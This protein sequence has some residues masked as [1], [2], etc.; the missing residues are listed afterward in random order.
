MGMQST[1]S[2]L[3]SRLSAWLDD[4]L[5]AEQRHEMEAWLREHPEDAA[6]VRLW[7]ADRDALLARLGPAVDEPVPTR[8]E[9]LVWNH[10][11]SI[12]PAGWQRLAA[13]IAAFVLGGAI[14][15]GI[16]WHW[17]VGGSAVVADAGWE[18]RVLNAH[19][20]YAP[21]LRHPVEVA[22]AG[23]TPEDSRA[24]EEQLSRWLTQRID[25]PVRLFDLR[26]LGFELLGGR[27]LADTEGPC[28]QLMYQRVGKAD[29]M[30]RVTV[31]MHKPDDVSSTLRYE[32][33]GE[34]GMF[35]WVDG[36]MGYA[37]VGALPREQLLA[38]AEA[39]HRQRRS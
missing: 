3:E 7:A 28:A 10:A 2:S 22:I 33:Q 35:Y 1:D 5:T 27:L 26:G 19:A 14:G 18:Q 25:R 21:D 8:L 34:L 38:L 32:R 15:A 24:Q 4:E 17:R 9:Q 36:P 29:A 31:Y 39:I 13:G 6:R 20:T 12:A 23:K 16:T 37:I 11:P 30:Q